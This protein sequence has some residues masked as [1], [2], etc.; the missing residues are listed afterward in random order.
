MP[1]RFI[2]ALAVL[3][4]M[5]GAAVAE[6]GLSSW[7]GPGFHG[8]KTASGEVFDMHGATCA[9]PSFR[10]G[11]RPYSVRGTNLANG[12]SVVCRVN[13]RVGAN[14]RVIDVSRGVAE[15]LGFVQSGVVRVSIRRLN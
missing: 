9:T 8:R 7:Y 11:Q 14:G 2:P 10:A 3:C 15:R 6:T 1:H 12:R 4:M 5:A 13:D